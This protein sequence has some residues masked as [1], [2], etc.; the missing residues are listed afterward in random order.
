MP[1]LTFSWKKTS[2]YLFFHCFFIIM[3]EN[4]APPSWDFSSPMTYYSRERSS[5]IAPSPKT[6][7][8]TK[9]TSP[10]R[11]SVH[12][13]ITVTV[14]KHWSKFVTCSPS[15]RE[16]GGI[17]YTQDIVIMVFDYAEQNGYVKILIRWLW[18]KNE[19][20]EGA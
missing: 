9:N 12:F 3:L 8:P 5:H 18:G 13:P 6:P 11:T 19:R 20:G 10:W 4:P 15:P 7:A 1:L 2:S 14:W 16:C 17:S